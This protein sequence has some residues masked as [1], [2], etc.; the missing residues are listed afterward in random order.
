MRVTQTIFQST[1]SKGNTMK[2]LLKSFAVS[3]MAGLIISGAALAAGGARTGDQDGTPD[4][5]RDQMRD[6]SCLDALEHNNIFHLVVRNGKGTTDQDGAPDQDRDQ[7]R[8][9]S[10]LEG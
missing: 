3:L 9:G 10:C 8:D 1:D 5:D 7:M 2:K 4:Q 6:D